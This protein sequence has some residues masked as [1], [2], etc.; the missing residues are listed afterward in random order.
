MTA[1]TAFRVGD[2]VRLRSSAASHHGR[3]TL[4]RRCLV[5]DTAFD[6]WLLVRFRR[7]RAPVFVLS[8]DLE[9]AV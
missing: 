7:G 8:T 5:V 1:A 4:A 3:D 9:E 2:R 6:P